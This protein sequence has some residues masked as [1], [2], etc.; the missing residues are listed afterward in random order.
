M[1]LFI[2][3]DATF[4]KQILDK[5]MSYR[6]DDLADPEHESAMMN[7]LS[8]LTDHLYLFRDA[9]AQEIV[10]L[11]ATF[12]QTMLEWRESFQ[13]KKDTSVHPW[14]TFEKAKCF[15]RELVK[16]EDEIKIE[17]EDLTKKETELEAQL[18]VIQSKS[19]LL[20]EERE[21][22]SKQMKIFWSLARDKV[23]KMEL[24][25]VKV[26][27]AN[28]QLEQRLKL[29]WVAMRHLF[30]IG[31]EGKNGMANNTQFPIH[32]CFL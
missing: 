11:K 6:L 16:A 3:R 17:L 32:H 31:W 23:S 21:E 1:H 24:K 10:K 19:Q 22:I 14:S 15:L 26:D 9:Q 20:K 7:S 2:K 5:L 30:G 18:E 4:A 13:V 27:S 29:K 8:T 28:Q 12:P 25:K